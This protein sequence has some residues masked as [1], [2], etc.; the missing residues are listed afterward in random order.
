VLFLCGRFALGNFIQLSNF[1]GHQ[2]AAVRRQRANALFT[3]WLVSTGGSISTITRPLF[4]RL[5]LILFDVLDTH[6]GIIGTPAAIA[7]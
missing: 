4:R 2:L 1:R 7:A 3:N 6:T 5:R